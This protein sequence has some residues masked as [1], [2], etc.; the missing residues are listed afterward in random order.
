MPVG[1]LLLSDGID[2]P[3]AGYLMKK[4]GM[5][6]ILLSFLNNRSQATRN[7]VEKIAKIVGGK[8]VLVDNVETQEKISSS[9]RTRYQCVLCKRAMYRKAN[10]VAKEYKAQ[11]LVTGESL[12]Q[13]A[14]QT[15]ENL[16]VLDKASG[17]PVL[18]PLIGFDKQ[19]IIE[20]A[21]KIGTFDTSIMKS[22]ACAYA[23]KRPVTKAKLSEV[24]K[25][26]WNLSTIT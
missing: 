24:E 23:P 25:E 2:I 5:E 7:K 21:K 22:P 13:V 12:G 16:S 20:I 3:V 17:L 1:V 11:F 18:R 15:I 14:S 9:C 19:Q 6:L 26:E 8:L 10:E 4:Q